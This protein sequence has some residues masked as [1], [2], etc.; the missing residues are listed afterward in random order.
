VRRTPVSARSKTG[1][2]RRAGAASG[3]GTEPDPRLTFA[4]ERTYLAWLALTSVGCTYGVLMS[5]EITAAAGGDWPYAPGDFHPE[6]GSLILASSP[7]RSIPANLKLTGDAKV[8]LV[9]GETP[10]TGYFDTWAPDGSWGPWENAF[11]NI[12]SETGQA[13]PTASITWSFA[14]NK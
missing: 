6:G 9:N 11:E 4:N 12:F 13:T 1:P 7:E 10:T 2:Q 3:P 8:P 14:P 5:F